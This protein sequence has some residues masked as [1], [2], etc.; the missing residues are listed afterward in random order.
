M[1][2]VIG[3][4]GLTFTFC[5]FVLILIGLL[6][7]AVYYKPL[8]DTASTVVDI[9]E[10]HE[11]LTNSSSNLIHDLDEKLDKID[12]VIEEEPLSDEFKRYTVRIEST[13]TI[14]VLNLKIPL[15]TS[16]VTKRVIY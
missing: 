3:A 13:L 2:K 9:I 16:K 11:G 6:G 15:R 14:P 10:T 1:N 4:Y 8:S 5:I 12:I 7:T